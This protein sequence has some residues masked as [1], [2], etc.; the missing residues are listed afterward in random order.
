M[1]FLTDRQSSNRKIREKIWIY[2]DNQS[3][4]SKEENAMKEEKKVNQEEQ[5]NTTPEKEPETK[6]SKK[7]LIKTV[8]TIGE[9]IVVG[10]MTALGA[11]AL[12]KAVAPEKKSSS[13]ET[14]E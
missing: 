2:S 10:G 5:E 3:K 13:S 7:G 1:C 4:F 8:F 14:T 12:F 9:K 11:Y 6:K